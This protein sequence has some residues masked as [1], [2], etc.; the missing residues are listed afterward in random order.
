MQSKPIIALLKAAI[1]APKA[2]PIRVD[3]AEGS[4][5]LDETIR[6]MK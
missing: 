4:Y 1:A 5:T 3:L 6:G 2:D